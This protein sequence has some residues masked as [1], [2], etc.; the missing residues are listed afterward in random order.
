M[1]R[2]DH[3]HH[4]QSPVQPRGVQQLQLQGGGGGGG[5]KHQVGQGR[6][7]ELGT[8]SSVQISLKEVRGGAGTGSGGE[9]T[10][11]G[12]IAPHHR[13][14]RLERSIAWLKEQHGQ[15]VSSLHTEIETLKHRN[16]GRQ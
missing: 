9:E 1:F 8:Q 14:V 4:H 15:M 2:V 12:N 16:R 13:I 3:H 10:T 7:V 5:D 11:A 6:E